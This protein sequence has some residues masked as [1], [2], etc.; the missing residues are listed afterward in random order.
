MGTG[1]LSLPVFLAS[2]W[3]MLELRRDGASTR[4]VLEPLRSFRDFVVEELSL[5]LRE[6]IKEATV[7]WAGGECTAI[8]GAEGRALSARLP[9]VDPGKERIEIVAGG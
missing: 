8:P 2:S 7:R 1:R 9:G 5:S 3:L 4:L 6:G